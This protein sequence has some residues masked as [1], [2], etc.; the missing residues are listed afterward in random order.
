MRHL[1]F[2]CQHGHF[3]RD[4][5]CPIDAWTHDEISL[6]VSLFSENPGMPLDEFCK[7]GIHPEL[8][9]RM[10]IIDSLAFPTSIECIYPKYYV[11]EGQI[12]EFIYRDW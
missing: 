3:F 8:V 4:G 1:F 5:C 2:R 10:L 6:A 12:D 11:V 7:R 9:R